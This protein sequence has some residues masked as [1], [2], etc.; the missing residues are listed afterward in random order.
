MTWKRSVH[1]RFCRNKGHNRATCPTYKEKAASDPNSYAARYYERREEREKNK[2]RTC[3]YCCSQEHDKRKCGK[4]IA[5]RKLA[6]QTN[7]DFR[8][9]CLNSF[10]QQGIGVGCLVDIRTFVKD[11]PTLALIYK[12]NWDEISYK[13]KNWNNI[14]SIEYLVNGEVNKYF[15]INIDEINLD[16]L[17]NYITVLEPVKLEQV[18]MTMPIN[19]LDG[20]SNIKSFF[21][22]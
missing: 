12:I 20:T 14:S 6:I 10:K 22:Q 5:D 3:S 21:D 18:T 4:L 7:S 19:W 17:S 2:S 8:H 16:I 11:F 1:C 15:N 9:R 13:Q